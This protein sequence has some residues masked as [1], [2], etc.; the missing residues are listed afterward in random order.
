MWRRLLMLSFPM[1]AV[2]AGFQMFFLKY[3]VIEKEDELKQIHRQILSDNRE[4]HMLEADWALA[5]DPNRLREFVKT[6]SYLKPIRSTQFVT[7]DE[8]P[9]KVAPVPMQKPKPEVFDVEEQPI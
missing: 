2:L 4:I 5:N 3:Q 1:I 8:L 6:Q 9:V 7:I